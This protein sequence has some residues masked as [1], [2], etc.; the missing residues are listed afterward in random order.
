MDD[1]RGPVSLTHLDES[2]NISDASAL[3]YDLSARLLP[4]PFN[5]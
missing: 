5:D 2:I 3:K 4:E 1:Q